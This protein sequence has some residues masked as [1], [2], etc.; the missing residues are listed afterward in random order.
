VE[1]DDDG[2]NKKNGI[3]FDEA[4]AFIWAEADVL[5]RRAYSTWL[6][7]WADDGLYIIPIESDVDDYATVLN[8]IYDDA[9]M[10]RMRVARLTSSNSM[11][12]T[13]VAE[14]VRTVS[15]FVKTGSENTGIEI[16][17]AQHLAEYKRAKHRLVPATL[18]I[19][20]R[21][22]NGKIKMVR[23]VVTLAS[24]ADGIQ[25]IAYLL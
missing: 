15:R 5:D 16:R 9:R 2:M 7:L 6:D 20:L 17:A 1:A 25:G 11:A 18:D 13:T 23:K 3:T 14:T 22:H 24:R 19:E 12:A 21:R 4:I 10:R 8:Y